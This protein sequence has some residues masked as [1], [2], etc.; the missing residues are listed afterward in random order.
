[1]DVYKRQTLHRLTSGNRKDL[2]V[3]DLDMDENDRILSAL[4][5][6]KRHVQGFSAY[7]DAPESS[8]PFLLEAL[9][10]GDILLTMGAGDNWKVG[11]AIAKKLSEGQSMQSKME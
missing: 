3:V 10:E 4:D 11:A 2:F 5:L 9:Q 7:S 1:G 6:W 8:V